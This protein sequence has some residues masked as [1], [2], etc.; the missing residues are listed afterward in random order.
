[1]RQVFNKEIRHDVFLNKMSAIL[2]DQSQSEK[3]SKVK[4]EFEDNEVEKG[5]DM[6]FDMIYFIKKQKAI[7]KYVSEL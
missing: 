2:K 4:R 7:L 5:K 3:L 6:N 1:M